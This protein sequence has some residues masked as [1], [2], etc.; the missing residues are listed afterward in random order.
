MDMVRNGN[1]EMVLILPVDTMFILM[2]RTFSFEGVGL[3]AGGLTILVIA[4]LNVSTPSILM[5]LQ[6]LTFFVIGLMVMMGIA[7]IMAAISFKWVGNSR[8]PEIFDS[9]RSFGK[10]PQSIFPKAVLV[11]TSFIFPVAMIAYY[12]ATALLGR[13]NTGLFI[14]ILPCFLFLIISIYI[15]RY[16]V[17]LY[18]GVG[19]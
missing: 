19:G 13:G 3:F 15:Y 4:I 9:I 1:M 16:M 18:Q 2:A 10:Y 12:P 14:M 17:R 5:C 11:V 8:I 7:L 6:F